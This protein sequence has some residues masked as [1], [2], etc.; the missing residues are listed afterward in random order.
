M[1][2]MA[3]AAVIVEANAMSGTRILARAALSMQRVVVLLEALMDQQWAR[4]LSQLP[5]VEVAGS[6]A[7]VA[8]VLESSVAPPALA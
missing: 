4:E 3:Q 5:G 6:T 7:E 2:G 8:D 1:A